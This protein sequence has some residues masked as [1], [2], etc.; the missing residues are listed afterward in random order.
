M[1]EKRC[2]MTM[3]LNS[4]KMAMMEKG[5]SGEKHKIASLSYITSTLKHKMTRERRKM[6]Q[7]LQGEKHLQREISYRKMENADAK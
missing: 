3:Y 6:M 4:C 5:K 2:K 7:T 1:T